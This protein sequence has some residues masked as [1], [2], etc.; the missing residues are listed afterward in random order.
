MIEHESHPIPVTVDSCDAS[1]EGGDEIVQGPEQHVGQGRAFQ[2]APEPLNQVE[3]GTIGR[4]PE[5]GDLVGMSL[6]PRSNR[7]GMMEASVVADQ[8]DLSSGIGCRQGHQEVNELHPTLLVG[9]GSSNPTSGEVDAAVDDFL[10]V[11]SRGRDFGLDAHRRPHP[12]QHGMTM[13]FHFVLE[14]EGFRGIGF[15][16][17]FFKRTSCLRAFA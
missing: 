9:H 1:L 11:L 6:Q 2:V 14:H 17:F 12:G 8:T 5:H 7:L 4:Q 15:Q 3:A 10:F 16:G 13:D